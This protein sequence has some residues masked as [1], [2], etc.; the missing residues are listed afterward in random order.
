MGTEE[1]KDGNEGKSRMG[2]EEILGEI[3]GKL[4]L[5]DLP[6]ALLHLGRHA[7]ELA[8]RH[9]DGRA[10]PHEG[11]RAPVFGVGG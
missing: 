3:D 5:Y 2:T 8:A 11:E 7:Y 10:L 9:F 4:L 1:V 6:H